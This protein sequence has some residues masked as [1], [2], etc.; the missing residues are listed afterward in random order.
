MSL[1]ETCRSD[2]T[3]SE[4]VIAQA[5]VAAD[6]AVDEISSSSEASSAA[7]LAADGD[8]LPALASLAALDSILDGLIVAQP[9]SVSVSTTS[10]ASNSSSIN[11]GSA[12]PKKGSSSASRKGKKSSSNA[13]AAVPA[14]TNIQCEIDWQRELAAAVAQEQLVVVKVESGRNRLVSTRLLA[15]C[16]QGRRLCAGTI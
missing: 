16:M 5:A 12:S 14:V 8:S 3:V 10:T 11:K 13:A 1:G 6:Q 4:T 15:D 2:G 9:A 7:T